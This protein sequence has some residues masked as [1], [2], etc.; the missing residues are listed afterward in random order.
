MQHHGGDLDRAQ[1]LY[2]RADWID[3]STGI[4]RAP[5]PLPEIAQEVWACLPMAKDIATLEQ[6]AARAY[7]AP[8]A[9]ALSGAQAAIQLIPRLDAPGRA[10]VLSP[11]YNEYAAA[12]AG[13]GWQVT[14]VRDL[15]AMA[16]ADLAIVVNPNNPDGR[17]FATAALKDLA[18]D[19]GRLVIDESFVDAVPALSLAPELA[20]LGERVVILRSFGK[21]YGLAGL[22]L[23]FVLAG[24]ETLARLRL[25]AGPWAVSGPAVAIGSVA[26]ADT[27]WRE[28]TIQR[29][30][31][32]ATRLDALTAHAGW[33]LVGGCALFRTFATPD[34]A[35]SQHQL[36]CHGIWSRRFSYDAHWLRL[37][38][39][40]T[41]AEWAR[42][43]K[44]L[45]D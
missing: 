44:A 22:R 39:P 33:A 42:L 23:G 29:L 25:L 28:A 1:A 24:P 5:Y 8:C 36:A 34:A 3:L 12:L 43:K 18:Q 6:V 4:N 26:L 35:Q 19:V 7:G 21:F 41:E 2:G 38:L 45:I 15:D 31:T 20:G 11:S 14:H 17:V 13:Q 9:L 16:G 10:A 30:T 32:E 40:G 37:G 27:A